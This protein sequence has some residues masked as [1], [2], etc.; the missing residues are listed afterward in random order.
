M[1]SYN[2]NKLYFINNLK[3]KEKM[4]VIHFYASSSYES[5]DY[6]DE[7]KLEIELQFTSVPQYEQYKI[8]LFSASYRLDKK[9]NSELGGRASISSSSPDRLG[10]I[11]V[12][13]TSI[14]GNRV[15]SLVMSYIVRWL[16]QFPEETVVNKIDFRPE[17]EEMAKR[18]YAKFGI[19]LNG[20]TKIGLLIDNDNWS[21]NINEV[22]LEDFV[23]EVWSKQEEIKFLKLKNAEGHTKLTKSSGEIYTW[24]SIFWGVDKIEFNQDIFIPSGFEIYFDEFNK[25][26][27]KDRGFLRRMIEDYSSL[28]YKL[29]RETLTYNNIQKAIVKEN[30]ERV[31]AFKIN[32][33][34][35]KIKWRLI[36]YSPI[37]IILFAGYFSYK[38]W[39]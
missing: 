25:N 14:R 30:F 16:K 23:Y 11:F 10:A 18:F 22:A 36:N 13:P 9:I 26:F 8:N 31:K 38:N 27:Q 12:D 2:E 20:Y 6:C 1:K 32:Y 21:E 34:L 3:S 33:F 29:E 37:L 35:R 15:G 19:P 24:K 4:G 7:A 5:N 39:F 28:N 17:K